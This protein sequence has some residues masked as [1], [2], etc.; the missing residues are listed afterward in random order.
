MMELNQSLERNVVICAERK[1]VF[2]YF[3]DSTRFASWWGAGSSIEGKP[4]GK[5]VIRY[6]GAVMAGGEVL[7][8]TEGERVVFTYGYETGKLVP[9]GSSR[10]TITL[11]DHPDGTLLNLR[12]E[13]SD[14]AARD[15]H[16]QGWRYQ[17]ALFANVVA[18]EQHSGYLQLLDEYYRVWSNADAASRLQVLERIA[19]PE[20]RFRDAYGCVAGR[21]ELAAHIAATQQ[22]MPGMNLQF[23]GQPVQCQGSA[24]ARWIARKADGTET[25]RGTNLF[26]FTPNGRIYSIVG[27]WAPA[28]GAPSA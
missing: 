5:V 20:V 26:H 1:T 18:G 17:L 7:E 22:H 14:A 6:P 28:A 10:V 27:F 19:A 2:R 16:V 11:K 24:M 21:E 15:M 4:G 25:A 23:D 9:A 12:H 13:F 3:T 8:I